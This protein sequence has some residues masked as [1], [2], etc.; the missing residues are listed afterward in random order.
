M[1]EFTAIYNKRH[2]EVHKF[3][4]RALTP[5][6]KSSPSTIDPIQSEATIA[7]VPIAPEG[8]APP[9]TTSTSRVLDTRT[10]LDLLPTDS[11]TGSS[12]E[13]YS[14]TAKWD[15]QI[16]TKEPQEETK[17]VTETTRHASLL[18]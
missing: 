10:T 16:A 6:D 12:D 9:T 11:N 1:H 18:E 3:V 17:R 4:A 8:R 14:T 13:I 2:D 15:R 5:L 7:R